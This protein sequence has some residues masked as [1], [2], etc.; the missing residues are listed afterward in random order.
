VTIPPQVQRRHQRQHLVL[1]VEFESAS[2]FRSNYLSDLSEGGVRINTS[3]EVGQMILLNISFL[4]FVEPIQIMAVAQWTQPASHPDGP[5]TGLAFVDPTPEVRAWLIDVLDSSTQIFVAPEEPSRIV[6]LEPEPF[7]REIYGQEVR[8][9]SELRDEEP[10]ELL[11][12]ADADA[13]LRDVASTPAT[14]A[15]IDIDNVE[16]DV[17]ELYNAVRSTAIAAELPLIVVGTPDRLKPFDATDDEKLL[18]LGKPLQF[19][20]LMNTSRI[21]ARND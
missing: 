8:N 3:L 2:G 6:L 12:L 21:L 10:L 7:L 18:C 16:G 19:G 4:G 17:F 20:V 1:K 14:L 9:W 15:I 13:W 5:A 11:V